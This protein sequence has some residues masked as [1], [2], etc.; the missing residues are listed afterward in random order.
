M[1]LVG[2]QGYAEDGR[3][4]KNLDPDSL[5]S[6]EDRRALTSRRSLYREAAGFRGPGG[7]SFLGPREP[8]LA[9]YLVN[10]YWVGPGLLTP[11]S[12]SHD[13]VHIVITALAQSRE[14]PREKTESLVSEWIR[15]LTVLWVIW[16][17][18]KGQWPALF[19][20]RADVWTRYCK[21]QSLGQT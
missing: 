8:R 13:T 15:Q 16:E 3:E 18:A 9:M 1:L 12:F 7:C 14:S 11:L 20:V 10:W 5:L 4:T 19:S 21:I 17:K 2:V 6:R